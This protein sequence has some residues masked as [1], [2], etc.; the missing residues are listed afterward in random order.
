ME[1]TRRSQNEDFTGVD[2]CYTIGSPATSTANVMLEGSMERRGPGQPNA[3]WRG[4]IMNMGL[5]SKDKEYCILYFCR[6]I[7]IYVE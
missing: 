7:L 6:P 3:K 5:N 4:V 2:I 1:P